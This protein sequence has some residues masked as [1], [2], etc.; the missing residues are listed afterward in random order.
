[1]AEYNSSWD[2]KMLRKKNM[3][4]K[5]S[6]TWRPKCRPRLRLRVWKAVSPTW[7]I[8]ERGIHRSSSG[9]AGTPWSCN[10]YSR[11][12]RIS[13]MQG[14]KGTGTNGSRIRIRNEEF[15]YF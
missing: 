5:L 7:K 14:Q 3:R 13:R 9:S 6:S 15:K 10:D 4:S 2:Y 11:K 8:W 12:D 1:M